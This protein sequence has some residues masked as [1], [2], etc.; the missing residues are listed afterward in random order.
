MIIIRLICMLVMV[1]R[2]IIL[3]IL[4]VDGCMMCV[5]NHY[6]SVIIA[7]S[8]RL[9]QLRPIYHIF[10]EFKLRF[11]NVLEHVSSTF[12]PSGEWSTW[13]FLQ[14]ARHLLLW[15]VAAAEFFDGFVIWAVARNQSGH[16]HTLFHRWL[17][18]SR[19]DAATITLPSQTSSIILVKLTAQIRY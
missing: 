14:V 4:T 15:S 19:P 13:L 9:L 11:I 7:I 12:D 3:I 5:F 16:L 10:E 2:A 18:V 17:N 8:R 6:V 1:H